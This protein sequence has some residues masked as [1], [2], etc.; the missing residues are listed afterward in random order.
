MSDGTSSGDE[1]TPTEQRVAG[2]A[3]SG[4]TNREVAAELFLSPKTVEAYLARIY[5]KLDIRSRAELGRHAGPMR[6]PTLGGTATDTGIR[7]IPVRRYRPSVPGAVAGAL[8]LPR[9]RTR[10]HVLVVTLRSVEF[11][12]AEVG[13][14]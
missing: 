7:P 14:R 11:A 8:T 12:D 4:L 6:S 1:L 10:T 13:T 5:R 9:G 3:A 2:L